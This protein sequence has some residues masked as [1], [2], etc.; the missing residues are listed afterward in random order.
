MH[1]APLFQPYV[2]NNG[3]AVKNRLAVA[4]MTHFGSD[5]HGHFSEA[6]R[7]FLTGRA[8]GFGLFIT[9]ATLVQ[10]DGQAFHGQ[11][12]ALGDGE[13]P[14]LK[15]TAALIQSQGAKAVLQIHH[16]GLKAMPELL[17][18]LP[19]KAPS[20][21]AASGAQA[22]SATEIDD[23]IAAFGRATRLAIEAGFDGVEIHGAN[24]YVLQQFLS[25]QTNRRA[26]AWGGDAARRLALPLAVVAAAV[27]AREQARRPD[28]IL[29]YRFSPEEPDEDGLTMNDAFALVEALCAQPLQY[30]H[31]SLW[32]FWKKARRGT[33]PTQ[34]RMA[35]LHEKIAGR[36]PLMGVGNLTTAA[37]LDAAAASGWA[38][39]IAVG[40]AVMLNPNLVQ[41]LTEGRDNEIIHELDPQ[42]ADGYGFPPHLWQ[43]AQKGAAWLPPVQ[44]QPW[45]PLDI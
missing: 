32:D 8:M 29:G 17:G 6:E 7:R 13:T 40:K 36:L 20:A 38:E 35:L 31:V 5:T 41:L 37:R 22:F 19:P 18:G 9:A 1:H 2:F 42:R 33:D 44:G 45:Q 14:S 21:D 16:G 4:P 23:L 26:D 39:F 43:M 28:F 15:A 11:P 24:G 25:A 12:F 34:T 27:A 30:L 3:V 10:R